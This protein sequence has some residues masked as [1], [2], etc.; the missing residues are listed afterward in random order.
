VTI[1]TGTGLQD[2]AAAIATYRRAVDEN[3]GSAFRFSTAHDFQLRE[4][5]P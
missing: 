2:V 3:A 1:L 5:A 4:I